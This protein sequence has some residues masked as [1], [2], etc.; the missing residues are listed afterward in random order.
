M[1]LITSPFGLGWNHEELV[2]QVNL[3]LPSGLID[4]HVFRGA[5]PKSR[6]PD[7]L[8][9]PIA[10]GV[11]ENKFVVAIEEKKRQSNVASLKQHN[12]QLVE[13]QAVSEC[14]WGILTD[15]E[16]WVIKRHLE[17]Y[18][19]FE[20]LDDFRRNLPD[21]QQCIG[22]APLLDRVRKQNSSDFIIVRPSLHLN[23]HAL[24]TIKADSA[25]I[26]K[27]CDDW[28]ANPG[29]ELFRKYLIRY[30]PHE[31]YLVQKKLAARGE[32]LKEVEFFSK[33]LALSPQ[34]CA[35]EHNLLIE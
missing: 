22:R 20:S 33:W 26:S 24:P 9:S 27:L 3:Q 28:V 32:L 2:P 18:A 30:S 1:P 21:I 7:I 35:V 15:G 13:Y 8:I 6:K 34:T 10:D 11:P 4:S 16:R 14:V 12:L 31:L 17:T 19:E 23:Q 5:K 25:R 29:T